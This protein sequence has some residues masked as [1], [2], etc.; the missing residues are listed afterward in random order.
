MPDISILTVPLIIL[1][2]PL[3][4][5]LLNKWGLMERANDLF[6]LGT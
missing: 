5:R 4:Q 2:S 3:H 1:N 6:A